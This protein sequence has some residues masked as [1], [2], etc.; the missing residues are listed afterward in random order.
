MLLSILVLTVP[1]RI[2]YYFPRLM[3]Q[4][5]TQSKDE[6]EVEIL[7][8][9]DNKKRTVGQKR[10]DLLDIAQG[11]YIMYV[12]DD[13]RV[14]DFFVKKIVET[15]KENPLTDCL[16]FDM[17]TTTNNDDGI[18]V[19]CGIEYT[20]QNLP[21]MITTKPPHT[22]PYRAEIAKKYKFI[23]RSWGEDILWVSHLWPEIKHQTRINEILYFYDAKYAETSETHQYV[24]EHVMRAAIEKLKLVPP[25]TTMPFEIIIGVRDEDMAA[26]V[27]ES[28]AEL[29]PKTRVLISKNFP[30]FS[31][32][33][34][35]AIVGSKYELVIFCSHRVRPIPADV[36]RM[37]NLLSYGY[38]LV[39]L[40]R[41]GFF[42]LKKE[43]MRRV[44][45]FDE[46]FLSGEYE[47]NDFVIRLK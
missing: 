7:A 37:L 6:P 39:G 9:F 15:L 44:G 27:I 45:F 1:S 17:Y 42:G 25:A 21:N 30:S 47:D 43:L 33:V 34:N 13:D 32:L 10:Q 2:D 28:L 12:D 40:Y 31:K 8:L 41:F 35:A 4:L 16:V 18:L 38:G 24:P 11:K 23:D 14:A 20:R 22:C 19:K 5:I 29:A 36:Y 26:P 3:N 46:R